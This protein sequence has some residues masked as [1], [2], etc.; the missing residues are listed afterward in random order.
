MD[1]SFQAALWVSPGPQTC[2]SSLD[3]SLAWAAVLAGG[4]AEDVWHHFQ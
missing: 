2:E 3:P 4:M 1:K